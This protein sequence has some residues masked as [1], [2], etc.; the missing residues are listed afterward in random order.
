MPALRFLCASLL[1][2]LA[3]SPA[4]AA[5]R[6]LAT[7]HDFGAFDEDDGRV[8]CSFRFVNEGPDPASI[9]AAR[10][11]CGCTTPRFT[12]TPIAPGD[13]ASVDVSFNPVGRPGRFNKTVNVDLDGGA[14][15]TLTIRG[16]VIGSQNTLRSR[17]PVEAGPLKLRTRALPFGSV[18]KGKAKSTFMEVYNATA[19]PQ[20]PQ[21]TNLPQGIRFAASRPVIPP[22]EQVV[23]TF[24][25]TPDRTL[26]YGILTDSVALVPSPGAPPVWVDITAIL[27]EDFSTLTPGQ[28]QK[29]PRIA[30]PDRL[31][32][33]SFPADTAAVSRSFQIVNNGPSDLILRRVYTLDPGID[34]S[35]SSSKVKK[36]RHATVT[37]TVN[38]ALLP[39]PLL[40]ARIQVIANDPENPI[41]IIRATGIP[42]GKQP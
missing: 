36:G 35:V 9:L 8:S 3:L 21:W 7:T 18:L 30:L 27:E 19:L 40:N 42:D 2:L 11:S 5:V 25:L 37:V 4:P 23:Y 22:G 38:P 34:I 39:A 13:T 41:S 26:L 32:F 1:T 12:K 6:W 10:A 16:V 28:R 15:T 14:R 20:E 24:T 29:A 31:D 33:G 17:Y